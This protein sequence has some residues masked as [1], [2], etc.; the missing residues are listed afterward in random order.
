MALGA[1]IYFFDQMIPHATGEI[2]LSRKGMGLYNGLQLFPRAAERLQTADKIEMALL[3]RR[4]TDPCLLLN[5]TS[6]LEWN[7]DRLANVSGVRIVREDG[8]PAEWNA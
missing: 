3:A 1:K 4:I 2:E 8:E 6:E 7:A 5:Q